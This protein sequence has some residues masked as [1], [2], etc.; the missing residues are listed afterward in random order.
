MSIY[1]FFL[2]FSEGQT[3]EEI[4][5]ALDDFDVLPHECLK[6]AVVGDRKV[7][8]TGHCA[9]L[10]KHRRL[11]MDWLMHAVEKDL[12][13]DRRQQCAGPRPREILALVPTRWVMCLR[14]RRVM[15]CPRFDS[16]SEA[17]I[18]TYL[19]C[20]QAKLPPGWTR[21]CVQGLRKS[22]LSYRLA[23]DPCH[24]QMEFMLQDSYVKTM[25]CVSQCNVRYYINFV[26]LL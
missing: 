2:I 21:V 12:G 17:E 25:L 14:E 24:Q 16:I 6:V 5:S 10:N 19:Q 18:H 7:Y 20:S 9:T 11:I 26:I 8:A 4:R 1:A 23:R 15:R 13:V 3:E 22:K